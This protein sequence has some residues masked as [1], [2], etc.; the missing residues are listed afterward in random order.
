MEKSI[1]ELNLVDLE[2]VVGGVDMVVT[3]TARKIPSM[4]T[5]G[6]MNQQP[7]APRPTH[8]ISAPII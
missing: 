3:A 4:P 8:P 7:K 2:A 1:K 5:S 6:S